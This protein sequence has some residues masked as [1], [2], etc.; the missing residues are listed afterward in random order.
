ME[1]HAAAAQSTQPFSPPSTPP[2]W[3]LM[4]RL[5]LCLCVAHTCVLCQGDEAGEA[6]AGGEAA[7]DEDLMVDLSLK[8]KKK[9]KK[10]SLH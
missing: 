8:K 10:V 3:L 4:N 7:E 5:F 9:K 1:T 2:R 6:A